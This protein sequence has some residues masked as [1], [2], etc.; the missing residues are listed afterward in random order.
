[1]TGL[2]QIP[3]LT[4]VSRNQPALERCYQML[5]KTAEQ[6]FEW[7]DCGFVLKKVNEEWR[8]TEAAMASGDVRAI[9]EEIGDTLSAVINLARHQGIA[10]SSADLHA[11]DTMPL[12]TLEHSTLAM[13]AAIT[14]ADAAILHGNSHA[15]QHSIH[16]MLLALSDTARRYGLETEDCLKATNEKFETRFT[17]VETHVRQ[18]GKHMADTPLAEL[19]ALW[20]AQKN[21]APARGL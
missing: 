9:S 11:G 21:T 13:H 15:L 7:P 12:A 14:R 8:E 4:R 16:D 18:Q 19:I 2:S 3:T 17:A 1:M 20:N 6:G 5:E 10:L